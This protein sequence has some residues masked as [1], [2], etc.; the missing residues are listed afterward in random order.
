NGKAVVQTSFGNFGGTGIYL[1]DGYLYTSS[2]SEVFRYKVD[3]NNHVIDTAA[4][5]RI[6]TGLVDKGTH[7]TKS[8]MMD[9]QGNLYIP[10]GAPVNSCQ[11]QDRQQGSMGIPGCPLLVTAGGV[12]MFKRDQKDQTYA[13]GVRYATGLRNV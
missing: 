1:R 2:N 4:P 11:E 7:E 6:V 8:I 9:G 13:D 5:E 3:A 10:I 12:W